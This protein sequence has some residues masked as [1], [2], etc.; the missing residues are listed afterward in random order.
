MRPATGETF[1][2]TR[3]LLRSADLEPS[4]LSFAAEL[5]SISGF[6]V[7]IV[8]DGR[9]VTGSPERSEDIIIL[10]E[11]NCAALGLYCPPDF[12]W[13]CGDYGYYLA[14]QWFADLQH[15]WMIETD[16]RLYG[17][18]PG[19]LFR[20]FASRP[21]IGFLAPLI[22]R[23]DPSW[24]WR[25][26]ARA[27][28]ATPY[29]CL[30]PLTRLSADAIDVCLRRRREHSGHW[31]RRQLWPNDEAFIATTLLNSSVQCRDLN[32]LGPRFYDPESFYYGSPIDGD[33][34]LPPGERCQAVHPIYFGSH[35]RHQVLKLQQ[36]TYPVPP[37]AERS[38]NAVAK[39][40]N[41]LSRW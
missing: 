9:H 4:V 1:P 11:D 21:E 32:D 15:F 13:K 31:R 20:F 8:V 41:A 22:G 34:F 28:D 26:T 25:P 17:S 5:R 29:R 10:S 36:R 16:V 18:E 39:K 19:Y 38:K 33:H 30:F 2:S 14:R 3:I 37:L 35:Y 24:Y 6:P 12:A 7:S 40:L 27:R 23:G